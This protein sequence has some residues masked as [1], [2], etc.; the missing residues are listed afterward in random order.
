[1]SEMRSPA[2]FCLLI[3]ATFVVKYQFCR[4]WWVSVH[5]TV[6]IFDFPNHD[7]VSASVF[8]C[9]CVQCVLK[10]AFL[11]E[12]A[13][14]QFHFSFHFALNAQWVDVEIRIRIIYDM[15]EQKKTSIHTAA[16]MNR[17]VQPNTR[18]C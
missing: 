14:F 12:T 18:V 2:F 4:L 3:C 17:H 10:H 11:A 15:N 5:Q 1:M 9:V 7:T 16:G 8:H 13:V 6:V